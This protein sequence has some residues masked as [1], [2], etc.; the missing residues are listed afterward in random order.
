MN[1]DTLDLKALLWRAHAQGIRHGFLP[2]WAGMLGEVL[3]P[4]RQDS[5]V[6]E[7]G[8]Q[9]PEFLRF[10]YLASPFAEGLGVVLNVD[11][12]VGYDGWAVSGNPRCRFVD[13][14]AIGTEAGGYDLAFS[15]EV[16]GLLADLHE[17]AALVRGLLSPGGVY[18]AAFGWHGDNPVSGVQAVIRAEQGLPF[19]PHRLGAIAEAFHTAGFEVGFKR[20]PLPY[21]LVYEPGVATRRFGGVAEMISCLQDQKMLFAFRKGDTDHGQ[22]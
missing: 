3:V 7:F 15:H 5:R 22:V 9:G 17:H 14:A 2:F 6:L 11:R 4:V 8:S 20:L 19:H 12:R 21:F 10:A 13:E 16:L 18:Y 1:A